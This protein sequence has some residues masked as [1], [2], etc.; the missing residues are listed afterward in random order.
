MW[1]LH[2]RWQA[3]DLGEPEQK[4]TVRLGSTQLRRLT[5]A[6]VTVILA[7]AA[8][9]AGSRVV[10]P[11]NYFLIFTAAAG[12]AAVALL[13]IAI[14][15]QAVRVLL[16]GF[17]SLRL[18]CKRR[19]MLGRVQRGRTTL[20]K[21]AGEGS[22]AGLLRDLAAAEYLRGRP[23]MAEAELARALE[24]DPTDGGLLNNL[25]VALAV[26]GHHDRAAELFTRAVAA[27]SLSQPLVNCALVAPLVS[28]PRLLEEMMT[29]WGEEP[30]PLALNNIGVFY[31]RRRQWEVAQDWFTAAAHEDAELPAARANLGLMANHRSQLQEAAD[32]IMEANRQAPNEPAFDN[33]LGVILAAA[34]QIDQARFYLRRALRADPAGASIRINAMSVEAQ[35]GHWPTA[36]RGLQ[37]LAAA[38]PHLPDAHY[39]L[40]VAQLAVGEPV[41]AAANAGAAIAQGD[42]S[43]DA[44]TVLAVSLWQTG[45]RAE[46]LSHFLSAINAPEAG[47]L[48]TSNLGRAL[49]LEGQ[50]ERALKVLETAHKEWPGD[51]KL[52]FDLATAILATGAA[53]Y[54]DHLSPTETQELSASLQLSYP[55]LE[56]AA[57]AGPEAPPEVHVNLG[58]YLYMQEQ[59][60]R[61]AEHFEMALRLAPKTRELHYLA[62]T[63]LGRAGEKESQK[64]EDGETS[65]TALGRQLVRR[66]VPDLQAAC[67]ARDVLVDASY[68][69]G[70]C[71]YV[72]EDYEGALAAFRKALRI[73][74]SEEMNTPAA[75]AAARQALS[76]QLAFRTQLL[77]PEAKRD[78]LRHRTL[79]LLNVAVH[80]FRQALLRNEL[81]PILHGNLGIAYMLRNEEH[82]ID[83]ALRHW[84]RMRTIGGGAM[85]ERYAELA[86]IGNLAHPARVGFDDRNMKLR[87]LDVLRWV[88]VAPPRPAGLRFVVEPVVV[89]QPWRLVVGTEI[90]QEALTLRDQIAADELRLMRLRV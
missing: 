30:S 40:A 43:A 86:Q 59:Y 44:Y 34:G 62:G 47:P 77:L 63:A 78:Q 19:M 42:S 53:H 26:Q 83:A 32:K 49:L 79:E 25:G 48:A 13:M 81:D 69:L 29:A 88:A 8:G 51:P 3:R 68:N 5:I 36:V 90:L 73:G 33:Y 84:E 12:G 89:H 61:A 45:R 80:Y 46:A 72:L 71:L 76:L 64:M 56:S 18:F 23:E 66:A 14:P 82:D 52:S 54:D 15:T 7:A 11:P 20:A 22:P 17:I 38:E 24:T 41:A 16:K 28:A 9:Y 60:E 21:G 1:Q 35:A 27:D 75:L 74:S 6:A 10:S 58:L 4:E 37:A 57:R 2:E 67:E 85:E 87:A 55:G 70:R 31:A 65:P 39:N 50:V